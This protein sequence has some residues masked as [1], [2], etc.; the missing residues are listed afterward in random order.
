MARVFSTNPA[1]SNAILYTFDGDGGGYEFGYSVAG[2]GDVNGDGHDDLFVGQPED[3]VIGD[4]AGSVVVISGS[5]G[6]RLATIYGDGAYEYFGF[7]VSAADIDYDGVND[8][9]IGEP[10]HDV[11]PYDDRGAVHVYSVAG[12]PAPPVL[13]FT[14]YGSGNGARFGESVAYAGDVNGDGFPD[15]VGGA[16]WAT[17]ANGAQSGYA[18]VYC[19]SPGQGSTGTYGV[20]CPAAT[21]LTLGYSG[22]LQL[23]QTLSIDLG[24]GPVAPTYAW[25]V[26][27]F[28]N[29]PP[30]P[31]SLA[32]LGLLDCTAYQPDDLIAGLPMFGGAASLQ[33]TVPLSYSPCGLQL[34]NQAIVLDPQA[35]YGVR[36]SNAGVV[37]LAP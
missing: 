23:G 2:A 25:I 7:C 26:F 3:K 13:L 10:R 15:F 9:I 35:P 17:T 32:V 5:D 16:P 24:N 12:L 27:A 29:D 28:S 4:D 22:S 6:A 37:V 20:G 30:F 18:A 33:L 11:L 34:Y 31:L 14:L 36:V 21:P 19:G 8:L 1:S